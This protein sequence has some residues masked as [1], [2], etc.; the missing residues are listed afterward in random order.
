MS[1]HQ[2]PPVVYPVG[3]SFWQA[4]LLGVPRVR[5]RLCWQ[6]AGADP[7]VAAEPGL[8]DGA[9]HWQPDVGTARAGLSVHLLWRGRAQMLVRL[10]GPGAPARWL[11]LRRGADPSRWNDLCR[12]VWASRH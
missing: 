4:L 11:W 7:D 5:G 12:A 6:P 3:L 8:A 10:R 9:W 1:R 2:A